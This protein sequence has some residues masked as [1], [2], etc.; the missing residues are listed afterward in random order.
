MDYRHNSHSKVSLK[1]HLIFVIKYRK[2]LLYGAFDEDVKQLVFEICK[3]YRWNLL[4]ME[5]DKDHLHMLI[6]YPASIPGVRLLP[7]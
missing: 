4:E 6:E 5:S 3:R 2:K 1:I 7:G